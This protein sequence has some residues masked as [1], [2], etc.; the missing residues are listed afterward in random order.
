MNNADHFYVESDRQINWSIPARRGTATFIAP[1]LGSFYP[2]TGRLIN[3]SV[4]IWIV[5]ATSESPFLSGKVPPHQLVHSMQLA[6]GDAD[7]AGLLVYSDKYLL[8]GSYLLVNATI[9]QLKFS[10][11]LASWVA[12]LK[13]HEP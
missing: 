5:T 2:E 3:W 8:A 4:P 6:D 11:H 10:M 13:R 9:E 12:F 1:L 7:S